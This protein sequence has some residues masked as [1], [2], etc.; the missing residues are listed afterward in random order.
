MIEDCTEETRRLV[1]KYSEKI[2]LLA[3]AVLLKETL[4]HSE[5]LEILGK[6]PF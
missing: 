2:K 1:K 4:G 6:R 3:E 5:I